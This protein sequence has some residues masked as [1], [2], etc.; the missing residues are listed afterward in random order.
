MATITKRS[1]GQWQAKVRKKGYTPHSKTFSTKAKA[2]QWA[3]M[4]ESEMDRGVFMSTTIAENT[5]LS[6]LLDRYTKE[7]A[8]SKKSEADIK[9]RA[10]LLNKHLGH[11]VLAAITPLTV[12][13]YR[14]YRLE[15]VKG[16]T[17]RKELS[18]LS[19][20]LKLAQQEWDIYLPRGNPVDSVGLPQKGK[21]RDRR[22]QPGEQDCLLQAAREYSGFIEDVILLALETGARRGELVNLQWANINL[23]K[24]TAILI[25]TKNGDDREVPLSSNRSEERRVGKE[26]RSRWSQ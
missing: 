5:Y 24:R 22:L 6:E 19:R 7:I 15:S 4:V 9:A 14:D 21:G 8:P 25:D 3:R 12:K 11:L 16:D 26:C 1:E 23:I 18:V 13:E 17:V 20:V 10:K 2:E